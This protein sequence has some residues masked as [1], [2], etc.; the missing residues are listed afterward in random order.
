MK[1]LKEYIFESS[2]SKEFRFILDKFKDTGIDKSLKQ[3]AEK[4]KIYAE[5]ID[6]GIK[7]RL[8]N[9]NY[10]NADSIIELMTDFA[11]TYMDK[12]DYTDAAEKIEST[13][14]AMKDYTEKLKGNETDEGE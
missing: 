7:I 9:S 6:K 3:T 4:N 11:N 8:D 1:S 14:T 5:I 12:D 2:D 13:V 10:K